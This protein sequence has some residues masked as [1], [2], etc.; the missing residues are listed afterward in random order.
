MGGVAGAL[1]FGVDLS[2]PIAHAMRDA[3]AGRFRCAAR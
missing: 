2:A 3:T 1:A